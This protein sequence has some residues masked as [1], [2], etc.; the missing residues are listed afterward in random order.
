MEDY[1]IIQTLHVTPDCHVHHHPFFYFRVFLLNSLTLC[2]FPLLLMENICPHFHLCQ[3]LVFLMSFFFLAFHII[4]QHYFLCFRSLILSQAFSYFLL[5]LCH[6][7]LSPSF[8]LQNAY[9]TTYIILKNEDRFFI[10]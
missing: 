2:L 6:Q 8:S 9:F 3:M 7:N 1:G 5:P 4:L 10:D